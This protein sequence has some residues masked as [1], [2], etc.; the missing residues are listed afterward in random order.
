MR[1]FANR[2]LGNRPPEG[3]DGRLEVLCV[4]VHPRYLHEKSEVQLTQFLPSLNSPRLIAILG[5]KA[6]G[7]QV[8]CHPVRRRLPATPGCGGSSLEG[9]YVHPERPTLTEDDHVPFETQVAGIWMLQISTE[10]L[11]GGMEHSV[12]VVRSCFHVEI[13]PE[14]VQYALPVQ[15]V[16]PRER[17][18][19]DQILRFLESPRAPI[20]G[21][22]SH[23]YPKSAK[24]PD[25]DRLEFPTLA[26]TG[27]IPSPALM[28]CRFLCSFSKAG[29]F[30]TCPVVWQYTLLV[31]RLACV[32]TLASLQVPGLYGERAT[33]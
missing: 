23:R 7:V 30:S 28:V 22:R 24:Q 4:L 21:S 17:E 2:L 14:F 18:E 1:L 16:T 25:P 29:N 6:S 11:A 19:L 27:L 20:D 26:A 12:P 9:L 13:W 31:V 15:P 10:R 32:P 33:R 5:Q 3:F 8:Q